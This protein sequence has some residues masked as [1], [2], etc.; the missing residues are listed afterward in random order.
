MITVSKDTFLQIL[1]F[2]PLWLIGKQ[3]I[4]DGHP[5]KINDVSVSGD[6]IFIEKGTLGKEWFPADGVEDTVVIDA[7][8]TK[9]IGDVKLI[10]VSSL[11]QSIETL[12]KLVGQPE[13]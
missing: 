5:Q 3:I 10:S 7:A 2:R 13:F 4:Y 1:K 9:G 6:H 8:S 12:E 11:T